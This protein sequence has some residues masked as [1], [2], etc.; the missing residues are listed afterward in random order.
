MASAKMLELLAESNNDERWTLQDIAKDDN[1]QLALEANSLLSDPERLTDVKHEIAQVRLRELSRTAQGKVPLPLDRPEFSKISFDS[2]GL[3]PLTSFQRTRG[4]LELGG[5]VYEMLPSLPNR[6]SC[7]WLLEQLNKLS[8]N[9]DVK[10]RLD[11][12]M[13]SRSD[14]YAA[15][16][17]KMAVYGPALSWQDLLGLTTEVTQ[18]WMPDNPD[19]SDIQF[20]DVVWTPQGDELHLKI[21]EVPKYEAREYRPSRYLHAIVDRRAGEFVHCDGAIRIFDE[22]ESKERIDTHV[23]RA[24]KLGVRIKLFQIDSILQLSAVMNLV[25]TFF[26][27]NDDAKKLLI[28]KIRHE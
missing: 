5:Y 7:F 3:V 11:P 18:R 20:T 14:E 28:Q 6:N 15:S 21:E 2:L 16:F 4:G 26:V 22:V 17:Y 10:I 25:S 23:R 8:V 1:S 24:G 27:W 13:R 19:R 9:I 12:F